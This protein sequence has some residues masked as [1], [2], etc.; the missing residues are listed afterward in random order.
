MK[1][2]II[3]A[4]IILLLF[5][6]QA[7]AAA[8]SLASTSKNLYERVLEVT[9]MQLLKNE[10]GEV[11]IEQPILEFVAATIGEGL[12][13]TDVL[14]AVRGDLTTL[15]GPSPSRPEIGFNGTCVKLQND[16]VRA[17]RAEEDL[18]TLG[19]D[20]QIIATSSEI[21]LGRRPRAGNNVPVILR[22][23]TDFWEA[24]DPKTSTRE[25]GRFRVTMIKDTPELLEAVGRLNGALQNTIRPENR[26][27]FTA[28]V[29][30]Y[31]D[32]LHATLANPLPP[33]SSEL[34]KLAKRWPGVERELSAIEGLLPSTFTPKLNTGETTMMFFTDDFFMRLSEGLPDTLRI[35]AYRE[36]TGSGSRSDIGLAA[37]PMIEPVFPAFAGPSQE[38]L[39]GGEYPE[40]VPD[41][42]A[43]CLHPLARRGYLC[44]KIEAPEETCKPFIENAPAGSVLLTGCTTEKKKG[45]PVDPCTLQPIPVAPQCR[46]LITCKNDGSCGGPHF[47]GAIGNKEENGDLPVCLDEI[48]TVPAIYVLFHELIHARQLCPLTPEQTQQYREGRYCCQIEGE[49]NFAECTAMQEDGLFA[50]SAKA[51]D[52][53]PFTVKT[54][55][56]SFT[57]AECKSCPSMR[58]FSEKFNKEISAHATAKARQL[59]AANP[60]RIPE[61]C[62]EMLNEPRSQEM[63]R[64]FHSAKDGPPPS[65]CAAS[66]VSEYR[67]T[68]GNNLCFLKGCMESI[69][70][71][72]LTPGRMPAVAMDEQAPWESCRNSI[73]PEK[74]ILTKTPVVTANLPSYRPGELPLILDQTLCQIAGLPP[75]SPPVSCLR[76]SAEILPLPRQS[77]LDIGFAGAAQTAIQENSINALENIGDALGVRVVTT[78]YEG[79]LSR[80]LPAFVDLLHDLSESIATISKIKPTT[81]QCPRNVTGQ[82]FCPPS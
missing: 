46:V 67:N 10:T 18:R 3:L 75:S 77:F 37:L 23:L 71:T 26:D 50:D 81:L 79:Y 12:L 16:I 78:M 21:S 19:R 61:R 40:D 44:R 34:W 69:A 25:R 5:E 76:R 57:Q 54:C 49:A 66:T 43:F 39:L 31:R 58:P 47:G 38:I 17:V 55:A 4:G 13:S 8:P 27:D 11:M 35:W 48:Q 2:P 64:R 29:W 24:G 72:R 62:S 15:C 80:A 22:S 14:A 73:N 20:L 65:T 70:G 1:R 6:R 63:L 45:K 41:G 82:D 51:S 28:A 32:G 53:T 9:R 56:E 52:G 42:K 33:P 68:I 30:R 36:E 59:N 60:G 7:V 74:N